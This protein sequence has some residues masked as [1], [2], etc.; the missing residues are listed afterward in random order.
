MPPKIEMG[1]LDGTGE[2]GGRSCDE[3]IKDRGAD[4]PG[5]PSA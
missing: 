3:G 1:E 2:Q 4:S 5:G